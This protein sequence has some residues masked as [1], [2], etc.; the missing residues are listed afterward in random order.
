MPRVK[1]LT[2]QKLEDDRGSWID[3]NPKP[4]TLPRWKTFFQII[5]VVVVNA[6]KGNSEP[7]AVTM[8]PRAA[9]NASF[10]K[11]EKG[12]DDV[13]HP[14]FDFVRCKHACL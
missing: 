6:Y 1:C 9:P 7:E 14:R 12:N 4:F 8:I 11:P 10:Y 2:F 3:I 5:V 13:Y